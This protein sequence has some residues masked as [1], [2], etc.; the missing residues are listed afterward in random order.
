MIED[1]SALSPK[2]R[3]TRAELV[4][5]ARALLGERGFD[6]LSVQQLC[7]RAGIGRTSFYTYF[8]DLGAVTD[9]L[10]AQVIAQITERFDASHVDLPRGMARLKTCLTMICDL[11]LS[12][13]ATV[14]LITSLAQQKPEIGRL[15]DAEIRA[16][17]LGAGFAPEAAEHLSQLL[18]LSTLSLA[19]AMALGQIPPTRKDAVIGFLLRACQP[20]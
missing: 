6:G 17:L 4:T 9:L 8:D 7:A 11:S 1:D 20:A 15:I 16:E 18:A 12:D 14:L 10:L 19:R 2:A 5:A 3:R 13:S